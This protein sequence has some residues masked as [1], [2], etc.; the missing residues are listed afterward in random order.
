MDSFPDPEAAS[1]GPSS[2]LH[3][4]ILHLPAPVPHHREDQE[5]DQETLNRPKVRFN[6]CMLMLGALAAISYGPTIKFTTPF[7]IMCLLKMNQDEEKFGSRV[8]GCPLL[9]GLLWGHWQLFYFATP[10]IQAPTP[11]SH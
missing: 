5:T 10:F 4:Y 8:V 7:Q 3:P 9:S 6:P 11:A 1:D 2:P